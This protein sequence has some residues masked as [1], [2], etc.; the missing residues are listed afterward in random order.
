MSVDILKSLGAVNDFFAED[1]LPLLP[2]AIQGEM[3]AAIKNITDV[4]EELPGLYGRLAS[5]NR[6]LQDLLNDILAEHYAFEQ[7]DFGS[8]EDLSLAFAAA[9][10]PGI[11]L[12]S[13]QSQ[14]FALKRLVTTALT[15]LQD[16]FSQ[17]SI[18]SALRKESQP[19]I[20][21]RSYALLGRHAAQQACFQSVFPVSSKNE[22]DHGTLL[23]R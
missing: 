2:K 6:E 18:S 11:S 22:T 16:Q 15:G 8:E 3:R 14:N 1:V 17:A 13:L 10:A 19:T 4:I 12:T 23:T 21:H 9:P 20:L 7:R 5:Q